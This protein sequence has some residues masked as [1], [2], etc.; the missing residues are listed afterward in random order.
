MRGGT[1]T[2]L[3]VQ[4]VLMRVS[5]SNSASLRGPDTAR[6]LSLVDVVSLDDLVH[7]FLGQLGH[8]HIR[9]WPLLDLSLEDVHCLS[10]LERPIREALLESSLAQRLQLDALRNR[11]NAVDDQLCLASDASTVDGVFGAANRVGLA[12][13]SNVTAAILVDLEGN[14]VLLKGA[15]GNRVGAR[16]G[17]LLGLIFVPNRDGSL[18]CLL[19]E[20]QDDM[21]VL[22]LLRAEDWVRE[23]HWRESQEE[24]VGP[25]GDEVEDQVV[26]GKEDRETCWRAV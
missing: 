17:D 24:F 11:H 20:F 22:G 6:A 10:N 12:A 2:E 14:G 25:H 3:D 5:V 4:R 18:G 13:N 1:Y 15:R 7:L 9:R 19:A 23:N 21:D 8:N 26:L 16:D